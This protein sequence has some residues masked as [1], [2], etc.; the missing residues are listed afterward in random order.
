[1]RRAAVTPFIFLS[2]FRCFGSWCDLYSVPGFAVHCEIEALA[3]HVLADSQPDKG[4]E[5][6]KNDQR[7]DGVIGEDDD[8]PCE[9]IEHLHCVALDEAGSTTIGLD[10]EHAREQ[11]AGNAAERMHAESIERIVVAEHVLETGASP[12]ADDTRCSADA[13][14]ADG[15]DKAGGRSDGDEPGNCTGADADHGRL[16]P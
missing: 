12:V 9:L 14:R 6:A 5:R 2:S 15:T 13:Q 3:L 4:I 16:A 1:M 8:D 11:R 7:H 10:R